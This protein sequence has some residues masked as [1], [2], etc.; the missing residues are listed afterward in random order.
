MEKK[1]VTETSETH[2]TLAIMIPWYDFTALS[3]ESM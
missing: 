2:S 3:S 1:T